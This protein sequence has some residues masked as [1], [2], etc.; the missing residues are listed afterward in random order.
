MRRPERAA[1]RRIVAAL[2]A[3]LLLGLIG[4]APADDL[5][6]SPRVE[7]AVDEGAL[8]HRAGL[9]WE[10]KG[11]DGAVGHLLGTI[12]LALPEVTTL[13]PQLRETLAAGSS[14]GMEV[15][16]DAEALAGV[17]AAMRAPDGEGLQR[18]ADPALYV[19]TV[20]LLAAYGIDEATAAGLQTWAVYTTLSLPP[21]Q[22]ALPLD[23]QLMLRAQAA[24]VPVFGIET[25]AEQTELFAS[26]STADQVAL[27]RE[28]VCHYEAQQADMRKLVDAYVAGDLARLYREAMRYE[29]PAQRRLL[30]DLLDARNARMAE[31]LLPRFATPGTFVAVG[32]LHLPGPG[33]LLERLDA[34]GFS[35]RAIDR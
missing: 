28:T 2:A 19:R 27:L 35:V 4:P 7:R 17:A 16:F 14:F 13:S 8:R 25:L 20:A 26:L 32:A 29:S 31:R 34:A 10:V 3:P 9:L 33:G 24:N 15:L 21:G 18:D 30:A 6:C 11:P 5:R 12:H 23:L 22:S 1:L